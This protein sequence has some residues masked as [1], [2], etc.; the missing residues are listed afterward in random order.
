MQT[1]REVCEQ[2]HDYVDG[3]QSLLSRAKIGLHLLMCRNC[4]AFMDQVRKTRSLIRNDAQPGAEMQV[5]SELMAA[6]A[7]QSANP[8]PKQAPERGAKKEKSQ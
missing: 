2:A 3:N 7:R 6:F 4:T 1:C 8:S 5:S